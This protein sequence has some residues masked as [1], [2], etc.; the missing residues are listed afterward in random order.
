MSQL[1][2]EIRKKEEVCGECKK[3]TMHISF[4]MRRTA[5][6]NA[7]KTKNTKKRAAVFYC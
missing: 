7:Q 2:V 3:M 4:D 1:C 6:V 5:A